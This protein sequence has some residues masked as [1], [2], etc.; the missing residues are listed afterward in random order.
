M[1]PV[2]ENTSI[3]ELGSLVCQTL[4]NEGIEAFLSGGAV[5]SIYTHNKYES[6]DLDFVTFG[7][8]KK[9]KVIMETLGFVQEKSRHFTHPKTKYFV[10]F[11][12][13][14]MAIGDQA[15]LEFAQRK[16]SNGILRLLTPT[17]CIKDRLASFI[18]WKDQQALDQAIM[19]AKVQPYKIDKIK[20]FCICEGS[21]DAFKEFLKK[22]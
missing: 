20:E 11:P 5:V 8:R 10:E 17:D 13:L 19:V 7:D 3:E 22:L 18:H 4:N 14:S 21:E 16:T 9:I 15:I 1:T 12:G 2:D 6:Y